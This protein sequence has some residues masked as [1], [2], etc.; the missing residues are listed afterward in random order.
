MLGAKRVEEVRDE[1]IAD[2]TGRDSLY[3]LIVL[4]PKAAKQL[5]TSNQAP[6]MLIELSEQLGRM[7]ASRFP[8][9]GY[10]TREELDASDD[11]EF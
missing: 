11:A 4:H 8:C 5:G 9:V 3:V 2:W 7:A 1:P 6:D 10:A